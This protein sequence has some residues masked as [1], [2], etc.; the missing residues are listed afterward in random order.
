MSQSFTIAAALASAFILWYESR[1]THDHILLSQIP[2]FP[3][4]R[5]RRLRGLRWRYSTLPHVGETSGSV[6]HPLKRIVCWLSSPQVKV[7]VT[8]RLT[9]SQSVS[10][11]SSQIWGSWPDIYYCLKIKVLLLWGALSDERTGLSF[12]YVAGRRQHSLSRIRVPW[13]SWPYFIV[14]DLRLPFS[15]SPTTRRYSN[16]PPHGCSSPPTTHRVIA[17]RLGQRGKHSS[18]F[19][20]NRFRGAMFVCVGVT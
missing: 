17:S 10:F 3:F 7:N 5:L 9:V 4:C 20:Y 15:S 8:L 19:Y 2:D 6:S 11:V 18:L 13:D 1:V 12:I 14:S 16:P